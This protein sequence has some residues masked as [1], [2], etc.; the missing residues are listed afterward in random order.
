MHKEYFLEDEKAH[1]K[2]D[3]DIYLERENTK[4]LEDILIAEN[5]L[6]FLDQERNELNIE[7]QEANEQIKC[8]K[9]KIKID[10]FFWLLV[11]FEDL[12][13]LGQKSGL[14]L[15]VVR[16]WDYYRVPVLINGLVSGAVFSGLLFYT[17]FKKHKAKKK[18][19]SLTFTKWK[20]DEDYETIKTRIHLFQKTDEKVKATENYR[21]YLLDCRKELENLKLRIS[22][23]YDY[24]QLSKRKYKNKYVYLSKVQ[25]FEQ[26]SLDEEEP[27]SDYVRKIAR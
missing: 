1:I 7:L 12:F 27:N 21:T 18:V 6:E 20:L 8:G 19:K 10:I 13:L 2:N 9:K 24:S 3:Q 4:H 16:I 11:L 23:Y 15:D 26:T 25:N 22:S 17:A 14:G 5:K